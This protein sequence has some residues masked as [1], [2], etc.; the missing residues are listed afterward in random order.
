MPSN[1]ALVY[2]GLVPFEED[3]TSPELELTRE[4]RGISRTGRILWVNIEAAILECY[5]AP[6]A[7][8]GSH[9]TATWL[10]VDNLKFSPWHPDPAVADISVSGGVA[11]YTYAKVEITYSK[12]PFQ[13]GDISGGS[14]T[15]DLLTRRVSFGGEIMTL[16]LSKLK[17]E[18][19]NAVVQDENVTAGRFIPSVEHSIT[20]HRRPTIN[21]S[22]IRKAIG[23][24]NAATFEGASPETLMFTG[25][26]VTQQFANDGSIM[27][28]LDLRFQERHIKD[29]NNVR[30]WNHFFRADVNKWDKLL[31]QDG[32]TVYQTVTNQDLY[33]LFR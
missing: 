5:P 31:T 19:N 1:C 27:N 16:P 10:Y 8:Y 14:A 18:S 21:W 26:E 33:D 11:S 25:A 32:Q 17:W 29:G 22:A 4:T 12:V 2:G 23:C 7:I 15:T 30:G 9:P 6:P 3:V 20:A 24:V 13:P 28:T